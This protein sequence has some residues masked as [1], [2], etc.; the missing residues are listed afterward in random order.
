MI[1]ERQRF[2]WRKWRFTAGFY[3]LMSMAFVAQRAILDLQ[4]GKPE[5]IAL[6]LVDL[7]VFSGL[8]ILL[9]LPITWITSRWRLTVGGIASLFALGLLLSGIHALAYLLC[10]VFL[11]PDGFLDPPI[12]SAAGFFNIFAGLSHAWRFLSFSYLVVLSYAYD[13]YTLS[14]D[15]ERRA[16]E[17]QAQ[18]AEAKL[19]VL[20]MQLQPHFL[21]NTINAIDVLIDDDPRAAQETLHHLSTLLRLTLDNSHAHEV[22]LRREAE[23]LATYLLIQRTRYGD[24][25]T[26]DVR[27]DPGILDAAIPYLILQP[28]VE[29]ALQHGIDAQ[30]GPGTITI[31]AARRGADLLLQV[32]DTGPGIRAAA[33]GRGAGRGLGLANTQAR[34]AQL[35]GDRHAFSIDDA[36][37]GTGTRVTLTIPYREY[38]QGGPG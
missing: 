4:R 37:A 16:G 3:I 25:L 2:D 8:W 14:R 23:F 35:Y 18:L 21:F 32:D 26:A 12:V 6:S 38:Q 5:E 10:G 13:Y 34:L 31:S 20:K 28:V 33:A 11:M 24:R 27:I 36:P 9:A 7:L 22:P 29:N 19:D 1:S 15:R 17:L 30:P